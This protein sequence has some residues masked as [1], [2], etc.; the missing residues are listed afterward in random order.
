[1]ADGFLGMENNCLESLTI[2][3]NVTARGG[4]AS[5]ESVFERSLQSTVTINPLQIQFGGEVTRKVDIGG[6]AANAWHSN[7]GDFLTRGF[8]NGCVSR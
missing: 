1:M 2:N 3:L 8:L 4:V 7:Q 6:T 5:E